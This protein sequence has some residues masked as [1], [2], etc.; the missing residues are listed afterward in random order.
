MSKKVRITNLRVNEGYN[1][2]LWDDDIA[3]K[4]VQSEI[5]KLE[6]YHYTGVRE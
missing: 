4:F 2:T 1:T 3:Q 6:S 5:D